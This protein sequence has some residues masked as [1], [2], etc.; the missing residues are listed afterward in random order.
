MYL[1][2]KYIKGYI[3]VFHSSVIELPHKSSN[4]INFKYWQ[5]LCKLY[6]LKI[7]TKRWT[8][9]S[10]AGTIQ[11]FTKWY[12]CEIK[13]D[14]RDMLNSLTVEIIAWGILILK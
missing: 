12:L 14:A 7:A 1:D 10:D 9:C 5:I 8:L 3:T 2:S 11:E 13:C 6:F 4:I